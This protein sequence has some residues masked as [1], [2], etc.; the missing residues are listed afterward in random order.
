MRMCGFS[1]IIAE[2]KTKGYGLTNPPQKR[3]LFFIY[4]YIF[5][6]ILNNLKGNMRVKERLE[7]NG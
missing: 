7:H 4:P 6:I 5:S 3:L 1:I 2:R